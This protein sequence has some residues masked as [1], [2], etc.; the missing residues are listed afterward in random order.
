MGEFMA[1]QQTVQVTDYEHRWVEGLNRGDLSAAAETFAPDCVIHITGSPDP[2]LSL[3]GFKQMVAGLLAAFP[4]LHF[5]IEDQ[6][7]A[8]DKVSTRWTAEGTNTAPL[9]EVPPTGR[10]VRVDGLI[11]DRVENGRVVERWEQWD[12]MAMMRQLGLL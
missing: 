7:V 1:T 12:Q 5:T 8:G 4:D 3:E 9:G 11:L 2:D 10:R 6:I